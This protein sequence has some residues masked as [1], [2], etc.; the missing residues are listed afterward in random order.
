M[1]KIR[2]KVVEPPDIDGVDCKGMEDFLNS[3]GDEGWRRS[4]EISPEGWWVF[5]RDE[6]TVKRED[7]Q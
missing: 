7:A 4:F 3:Y 5:T 1:R 6:F 2:Y